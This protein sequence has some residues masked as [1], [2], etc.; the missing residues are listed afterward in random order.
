MIDG[1]IIL[2]CLLRAFKL[3]DVIPADQANHVTNFRPIIYMKLVIISV[4]T[5][6]DKT[7][8]DV[9]L[10]I[11]IQ[12]ER[13]ILY[14]DARVNL[15]HSNAMSNIRYC[16]LYLEVSNSRKFLIMGRNGKRELEKEGINEKN[17]HLIFIN[18]RVNIISRI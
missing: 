9:E 16:V 4:L 7:V 2:S 14:Y 17:K 10:L 5:I 3:C 8:N 6:R 12:S 18:K 13:V 1:F 11:Q 15:W